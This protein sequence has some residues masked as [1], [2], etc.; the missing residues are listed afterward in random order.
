M[1]RRT[2]QQQQ[3]QQHHAHFNLPPPSESVDHPA[4]LE[5]ILVITDDAPNAGEDSSNGGGGGNSS[6]S[7]K[8]K[9][10]AVS[11]D[12]SVLSNESG[13]SSQIEYDD[14]DDLE[15]EEGEDEDDDNDDEESGGPCSRDDHERI[16]PLSSPPRRERGEEEKGGIVNQGRRFD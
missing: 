1:N 2:G 15:V 4:D 12:P 7:F 3:Q 13:I 6:S 5:S 10:R 14:Y 11:E 9:T 8:E 16:S